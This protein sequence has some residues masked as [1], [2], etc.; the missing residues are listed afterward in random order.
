MPVV[1]VPHARPVSLRPVP[2]PPP[3]A[4][5]ATAS[6]DLETPAPAEIEALRIVRWHDPVIDRLGYDPRSLYV[7]TF[8][9]AVLGP[10]CTWLLR[11]LAAGLDDDPAGFDLDLGE[12]ARALGLGSRSGRQSP[13]RRALSRCVTFQMARRGG[14]ATLAVRGRIPPMPRRHLIRLSP[15]L[16]E[17][18][19]RWL[20]PVRSTPVLEEARRHARR[21]ALA[22]LASDQGRPEVE[23]QLVR[24]RVHPAIAHE[25]TQWAWAY[26]AHDPSTT[27]TRRAGR[28]T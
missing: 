17:R 20:V 26:R 2:A 16:Q 27:H 13:M 3:E 19:A 18:H 1:P 24:W 12:T 9:L 5:S 14:P 11:R 21:L 8:W 28:H 22:L 10:T 23:L 25:A 15:T 7:E 4:D 6:D